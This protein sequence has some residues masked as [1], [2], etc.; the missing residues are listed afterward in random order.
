MARIRAG[1][2][3]RVR[4]LGGGEGGR[5]LRLG[6]GER[7]GEG[8]RKPSSKG[9]GWGG[10]RAEAHRAA[11]SARAAHAVDVAHVVAC[12]A[13]ARLRGQ[14]GYVRR[15]GGGSAAE[16]VGVR[17]GGAAGGWARAAAATAE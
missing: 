4:R 13:R 6:G 12:A 11:K 5:V 14:Y 17:G 9:R 2:C 15:L 8:G 3:G 7:R 16:S 1:E 10:S